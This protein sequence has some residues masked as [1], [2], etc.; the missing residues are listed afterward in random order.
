[1][2]LYLRQK[3]YLLNIFIFKTLNSQLLNYIKI[4]S[5]YIL[6]RYATC[7]KFIESSIFHIYRNTVTSVNVSN[8]IRQSIRGEIKLLILSTVVPPYLQ[9]IRPKIPSGCLKLQIVLNPIYL[10]CF[11]IHTYL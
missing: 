10:G 1:M 2:S 8:K 11:P 9:G 3:I 7:R 5:Q 6:N 4:I